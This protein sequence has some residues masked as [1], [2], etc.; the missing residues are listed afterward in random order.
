MNRVIQRA[1]SQVLLGQG[2]IEEAVALCTHDHVGALNG[3]VTEGDPRHGPR[4]K[5]YRCFECGGHVDG[6]HGAVLH[7]R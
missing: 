7:T 2:A 6:L 1:M 5:G 3:S 4:R